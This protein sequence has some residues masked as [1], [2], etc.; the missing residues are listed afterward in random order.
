[1]AQAIGDTGGVSFVYDGDCAFCTR[2]ARWARRRVRPGVRIV[3]ASDVGLAALGL[4]P[5][6]AA[7]AAWWVDGG[8]RERG[9]RAIGFLLRASRAW[10][11]RLAGLLLL[12]PGVSPLAGPAYAWIARNRHRMPGGAAACSAA[13]PPRR[14]C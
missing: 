12:L 14:D 2:C 13:A 3:A 1:M 10:W 6:Q 7:E 9:H 8:R 4:T 11:W 5:A